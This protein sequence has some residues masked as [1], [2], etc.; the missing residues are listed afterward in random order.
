MAFGTTISMN[1]VGSQ[2]GH[3]FLNPLPITEFS[4][5]SL[6]NL[7][8]SSYTV[9]TIGIG[10]SFNLGYFQNKIYDN[11]ATL[12]NIL[13]NSTHIYNYITSSSPPTV[14]TTY[15]GTMTIL[16][17]VGYRNLAPSLKL[18]RNIASGA[19]ATGSLQIFKN[20]VLNQT[21]SQ[22]YYGN[23]SITVNASNLNFNN[24]DTFKMILFNTAPNGVVFTTEAT[25]DIANG[26]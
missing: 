11:T 24:N 6:Y 7:N 12:S 23:G 3:N 26:V 4:G 14:T 8:G 1:T 18:T 5:K 13:S 2:F 15:E 22:D 20:N 16:A 17:S 10:N 9:P 19:P 21:L 25:C